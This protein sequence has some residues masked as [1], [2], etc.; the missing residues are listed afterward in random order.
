MNMKETA[1][2][3]VSN[4]KC[5]NASLENSKEGLSSKSEITVLPVAHD[6]FLGGKR[7][8]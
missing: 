5:S 1:Q 2:Q 7:L 3:I 6:F 4:I 8:N